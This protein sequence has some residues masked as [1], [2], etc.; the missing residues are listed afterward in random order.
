MAV[1]L[2]AASSINN[3]HMSHALLAIQQ[4][5]LSVLQAS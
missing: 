3:A 2:I 1:A 4:C 5:V